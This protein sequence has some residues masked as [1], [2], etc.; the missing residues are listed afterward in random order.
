M[1]D[2][3][4]HPIVWRVLKQTAFL[5]YQGPSYKMEEYINYPE[6]IKEVFKASSRMIVEEFFKDM[7][8]NAKK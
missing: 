4:R 8:G 1:K 5:N 6:K 3:A 2:P 7:K